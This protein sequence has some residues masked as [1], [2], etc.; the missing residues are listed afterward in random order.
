MGLLLV[1]GR[2][3]E[4]EDGQPGGHGVCVCVLRGSRGR[5]G[6]IEGSSFLFATVLGAQA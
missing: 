2:R 5:E 6:G 1:E 4:G 3:R